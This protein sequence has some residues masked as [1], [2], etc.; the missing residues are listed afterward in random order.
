MCAAHTL[1]GN[2][3][4]MQT[5]LNFVG[6]QEAQ[7]DNDIACMHAMQGG[8]SNMFS[9]SQL[10]LAQTGGSHEVDAEK[11]GTGITALAT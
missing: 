1:H 11:E 6:Q 5:V 10:L 8:C 4:L 2:M 7:Q 3:P 9:A